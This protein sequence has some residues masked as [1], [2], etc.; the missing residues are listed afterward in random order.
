IV[1][2]KRGETKQLENVLLPSRKRNS[3]NI[4]SFVSNFLEYNST[5]RF[6]GGESGSLRIPRSGA[7]T[8]AGAS[9]ILGFGLVLDYLD[10]HWEE[11][12]TPV[13]EDLANQLLS[14]ISD[15]AFQA[16][17]ELVIA[18]VD[19]IVAEL[20]KLPGTDYQVYRIVA[21]ENTTVP[22]INWGDGD[23]RKIFSV[24]N[25]SLKA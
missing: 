2:G 22:E 17:F 15:P 20:N 9:G 23:W 3:L 14:I 12:K 18:N 4:S 8:G 5:L 1:N 13:E 21:A 6:G 16:H 10:Q 7:G 11:I 19:A 25:V 24:K